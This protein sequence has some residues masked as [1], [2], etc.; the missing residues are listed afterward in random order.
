M[1]YPEPSN[2]HETDLTVTDAFR[3]LRELE[4]PVDKIFGNKF[5][6]GRLFFRDARLLHE[7]PHRFLKHQSRICKYRMLGTVRERHL[8]SSEYAEPLELAT[9]I[10]G[11]HDHLVSMGEELPPYAYCILIAGIMLTDRIGGDKSTGGGNVR[12][13]FDSILC[14][15]KPLEKETVFEYLDS[16]FYDISKEEG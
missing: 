4:S 7:P 10:D 5:E 16:E 8:F 2:P 15:G 14:D 3:P 1:R 9:T 12:I 6:S 11:Y 13:L